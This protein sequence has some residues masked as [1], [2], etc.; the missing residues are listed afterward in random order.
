M[1]SLNYLLL[2]CRVYSFISISLSIYTIKIKHIVMQKAETK[3]IKL[4]SEY[5]GF[6]LLLLKKP[7]QCT[8]RV[9]ETILVD[10]FGAPKEWIFNSS[11][12]AHHPVL[13]KR[14]ENLLPLLIVKSI[15][16]KHVKQSSISQFKTIPELREYVSATLNDRKDAEFV[17][18]KKSVEI[19]TAN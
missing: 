11:K 12:L 14:R 15:C 18:K 3:K 5:S 8:V 16:S 13:K 10:R 2:L 4:V 6:D 1:I 7:L 17:T 19:R 9:P